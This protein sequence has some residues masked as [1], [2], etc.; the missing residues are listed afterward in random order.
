M[1]PTDLPPTVVTPGNH[2]GVHL[3]HR[4]LISTARDLAARSGLATMG[5]CFDPHPTSVLAPDRAPVLLTPMARRVELMRGAGCDEV[6]VLTFDR[7]FAQTSPELFVQRVLVERCRARA[8]VVGP[9]FHFGSKRAG[10]VETLRDLGRQH[11]F[12]VTVVRPVLFEGAPVSST[13]VRRLLA[14][15]GDVASVARML[16][17]VHDVDGV[18]V[19]GDQRGRTIGFHTA[20]LQLA[21]VQLPADGVYAVV[22][23]V[24]GGDGTR[25]QG[26][27]NLGQ[28][29]TFEAGRSVEVHLLDFEGDL[30]GKT[31]RVGFVARV[32]PEQKFDGVEAL[33]RQINQDC[34]RARALL[35][36]AEEELLRWI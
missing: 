33:V 12:T 25:L 4:A 15:E 5:M 35:A 20:N 16:T 14:E 36:V 11:G 27:A 29:P 7:D 10:N 28:R 3:G 18:V 23:S 2:D 13:R 21:D 30:Y 34:V 26:V 19:R 22:V 6:A 17:R 8:V 32:R 1:N 9:D 31:L 24:V